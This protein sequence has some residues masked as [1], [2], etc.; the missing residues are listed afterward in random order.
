MRQDYTP[1]E[2]D[3]DAGLYRAMLTEYLASLPRTA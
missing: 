1:F 2:P 3:R